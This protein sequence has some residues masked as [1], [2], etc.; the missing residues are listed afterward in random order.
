MFS[1]KIYL[2]EV[3]PVQGG[4]KLHGGWIQILCVSYMSSNL[5][6]SSCIY[7]NY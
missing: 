1:Y 5:S 2:K 6:V 7:V 4:S 3:N